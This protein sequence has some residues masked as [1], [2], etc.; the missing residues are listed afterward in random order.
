MREKLLIW[1]LLILVFS[2]FGRVGSVRA[3]NSSL[4]ANKILVLKNGQILQGRITRR[5]D[6]L[7]VETLQGSRLVIQPN[8]ADFVADSMAD[9]YWEKCAQTRASDLK[10]QV[11]LFFWCL[12]HHLL[13]LAENQFGVISELEIP[14][15]DLLGL[16]RQLSVAQQQNQRATS[17]ANEPNSVDVEQALLS[18]KTVKK[19]KS[20]AATA[21]VTTR[22]PQLTKV[23][24]SP[25]PLNAKRMPQSQWLAKQDELPEIKP[26][27]QLE[28]ASIEFRRLP[29][30][31]LSSSL[32]MASDT[33]V[34]E[35]GSI[36]Q[37]GFEEPVKDSVAMDSDGGWISPGLPSKPDSPRAIEPTN[38]ASISVAEMQAAI[39]ELPSPFVG[40]FRKRV[41]KLFTNGCIKCHDNNDSV[42]PLMYRSSGQPIS[43]SLS[44]RNLYHLSRYLD[45]E[46]PLRSPVFLAA[47]EPHQGQ[48]AVYEKGSRERKQLERWLALLPGVGVT[49]PQKFVNANQTEKPIREVKPKRDR[50][51]AK[52]PA[53][54]KSF[55]GHIPELPTGKDRYL[56]K[57][58]FDPEIFNRKYHR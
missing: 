39:D 7:I 27:P 13:D 22:P 12:Q 41:Q 43:Q 20:S 40:F 47:I 14:A 3:Q 31:N 48:P 1:L 45:L 6:Q 23:D 38:S 54:L 15:K 36:R 57:D 10:G 4:A 26:L 53:E 11:D 16:H 25:K 49:P 58:A 34:D 37:V 30:E 56:P 19:T 46:N 5:A 28:S 8:R 44:R 29:Q 18:Q 42:M 52:L 33:Q 55:D 35:L 2:T 51:M 21:N 50:P 24:R 9:A 32:A 17:S